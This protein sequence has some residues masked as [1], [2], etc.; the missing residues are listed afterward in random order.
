M[1]TRDRLLAVTVAVAWGLN[2]IAIDQ[3][4]TH[5]PPFLLVAVRFTLMA[6]PTIL[7]VPWPRVR[8]TWWLLYGLGF[9]VLQFGFLFVALESGMPTGLASL[10]LQSSAPFTVLLGAA[11]LGERL[12]R[13]QSL[14]IVVAVVGLAV[15]GL[16]RTQ[17]ASWVPFAL[18]LCAG[19]GWALG[20]I[21][22]R[23]ARPE[24]PMHLMLWMTVVPPVPMLAMSW[25]F[26]GRDAITSSLSTMFTADAL[27]AL[28]GVAYIVLIGTVLGSG[29]WTSL[30]ARHPSSVVAPFSMLVPVVGMT[31]AVVLLGERVD[32]TEVAG[33]A[34]VV[35][36]VGW[37]STTSRRRRVARTGL[38]EPVRV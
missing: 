16:H 36:G 10:V 13:R 35:A 21:G 32:V 19:L 38:E 22:S 5:F 8:W 1:S 6:V 25:V 17:A 23:Q 18:T 26:E 31:A 29:I 28:L 15:V 20:N 33:A 14:G 11:F 30:M 34:L 24:Q 2:F 7:L 4:L 27:P 37:A 9:G 12:S 3:A